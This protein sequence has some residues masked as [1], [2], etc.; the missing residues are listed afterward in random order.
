MKKTPKSL[1][2]DEAKL[3]VKIRARYICEKC[4]RT[5]DQI[6]IHGAHI[7]PV[8]YNG[9]AAEPE[10]ILSLCA[11]CHSM[12]S[13]SAH[14]Q[15]QEYVYWLDQTFPGRYQKMREMAQEYTRNP[16]PKKDWVQIRAELKKLI[17]EEGK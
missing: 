5:R 6:Q 10:N 11:G 12:G 9:T 13:K 15:P 8:T 3:L 16:K 1:A 2:V 7:M 4:G 17:K 14:Q